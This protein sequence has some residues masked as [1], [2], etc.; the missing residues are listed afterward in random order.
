MRKHLILAVWLLAMAGVL[1]ASAYEL[2]LGPQTVDFHGFA[3]QGYLKSTEGCNFFA[4]SGDSD[5][6][7]EFTEYG[8][9]AAMDVT[10]RIRVGLQVYGRNLGDMG[11][12]EPKL[13]WAFVDY[14]FQDWLG[15]RAG[16]LKLAHGLYNEY[17]DYDMLRTSIILPQSVYLETMRDAFNSLDGMGLYGNYAIDKVGKF[18]YQIQLGVLNPDVDGGL[19]RYVESVWDVGV[20]DIGNDWVYV[21]NLQWETPVE[22]L[23]L[24]YSHVS[25][26]LTA[27][28]TTKLSGLWTMVG[29]PVGTPVDL[30]Q[31]V[32]ANAFSAE[33]TWKELI[34]AAEY[35][36]VP[37]TYTLGNDMLGG[38][39]DGEPTIEGYYASASYRFNE[40][41]QLGL[42]YSEY[43]PN[44]KDKDGEG[45]SQ[46][47]QPRWNGWLKDLGVTGRFDFL[48]NWILK[49]EVHQMNGGAV[50]ISEDQRNE[51]G[52]YSNKKDWYLFMAKLSYSF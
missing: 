37:M 10:D 24:G 22:G 11:D 36:Y 40:W 41:F 2:T 12:Y 14:R 9:N 8:L 35:I 21:I 30:D 7:F 43:F 27:E 29:L 5:G 15:V 33:Y 31:Q 48:N 28:S 46:M 4:D 25:F 45:V 26:N 16:R 38:L 34:L 32:R 44:N 51:D 6:S 39:V 47:G 52:S 18:N 17:R 23:R 3:S 19:A 13:D 42:C 50:M 20:N 1:S 49:L